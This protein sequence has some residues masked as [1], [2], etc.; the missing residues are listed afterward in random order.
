[1]ATDEKRVVKDAV[2]E[3]GVEEL[4]ARFMRQALVDAQQY[5][6]GAGNGQAGGFRSPSVWNAAADHRAAAPGGA[7]AER[8]VR[9][10]R[11]RRQGCFDSEGKPTKAALGFARSTGVSVEALACGRLLRATTSTLRSPREVGRPAR[12]WRRSSHR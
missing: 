6:R 3:I 7:Q 11:A 10:V 4:P 5:M 2:L 1:M 9:E 12:C 8:S